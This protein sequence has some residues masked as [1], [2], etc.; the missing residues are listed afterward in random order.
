MIENSAGAMAAFN[1]EENDEVGTSLE[2]NEIILFQCKSCNA[3]LADS[4]DSDGANSDLGLVV[5][6]G[7]E[8]L[9]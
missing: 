7:E 9:N 2:V 5:L 6:Q 8:A 4:T 3:V 1:H